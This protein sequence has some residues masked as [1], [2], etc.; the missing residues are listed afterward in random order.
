M[1]FHSRRRLFG[2]GISLAAAVIFAS[3][4]STAAAA[5]SAGSAI[6]NA[7]PATVPMA[8]AKAATGGAG[9]SGD[10]GPFITFTGTSFN[11]NGPYNGA[12]SVYVGTNNND[13]DN[14]AAKSF[15]FTV[16]SLDCNVTGA[17]LNVV[18]NGTTIGKTSNAPGPPDET[19]VTISRKSVLLLC[20][21]T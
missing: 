8:M 15:E 20:I 18:I 4:T 5:D 13:A 14:N 9:F 3:I 17:T 12:D 1:H 21:G 10:D 16:A 2:S 19:P 11:D 6:I 7:L